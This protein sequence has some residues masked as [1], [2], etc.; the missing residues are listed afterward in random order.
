MRQIVLIVIVL[1]LSIG[2]VHGKDDGIIGP[3]SYPEGINPLTGLPV[4]DADVLNRRP[5]MVKIINAPPEVRPQSGLMEADIVW[6][7]LLAGGIT[8]FSAFYLGQ[9]VDHLGPVRSARLVDFELVRMYRSLITYSGMAEGTIAVL[10]TDPLMISRL[11]GGTDPCPALCRF[12]DEGEKLEWTLFG[13]TAALREEAVVR[14]RD[15]T[16]EP[17]YGMAF[18]DAAPD[19]GVSVDGINIAYRQTNI[20]WTYDAETGVWMREQDGEPHFDARTE[21]QIFATNVMILEEEHVEQ[22]YVREG[23]WG[24]PNYAFSVN[25]IGS[26]RAVLLRDGQYF[27]GEWR[28][29]TREDPLTFFDAEGNILPFKPGTTFFNLMPRWVGGYQLTFGLTEPLTATVTVGSANLRYGPTTGYPVGGA[30]FQGDEL[31]AVGRNNAGD[32]V[33]VMVDDVPLWGSTMVISM[34]DGDVMSLPLSRSTI[35][36]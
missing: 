24:P 2:V 29:E 13:D 7:H 1:V 33:Q 18:S 26:G 35:E 11:V 6:E 14:E 28:R 10:S 36:Q 31:T 3:D 30:G 5:L 23:Y 21:E 17:V 22:P 12:P 4:E 9:D 20:Q 8:R 32:W 15:T 25:F 34:G 16:P 27:E 19:G